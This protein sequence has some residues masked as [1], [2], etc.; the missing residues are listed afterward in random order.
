MDGSK[1]GTPGQTKILKDDV[2][3]A[4][5]LASVIECDVSAALGNAGVF[6]CGVGAASRL[7]SA[8]VLTVS[9]TKGAIVDAITTVRCRRDHFAERCKILGRRARIGW[10]SRNRR[11][12]SA[13]SRAE[14]YG[15]DGSFSI[16]LRMIV[17]KS[18]GIA[19]LHH[20]QLFG[21]WS[22][23]RL[24]SSWRLRAVNAGLSVNSS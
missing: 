2:G 23:I 8:A 16:A 14:A 7:R 1:L 10:W 22:R 6:E 15:S 4:S 5:G 13:D 3:A 12:S 11:S 21:S 9:V 24:V 20:G 17:S 18:R 19:G